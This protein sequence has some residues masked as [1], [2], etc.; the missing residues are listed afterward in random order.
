[1]FSLTASDEGEGGGSCGILKNGNGPV[2]ARTGMPGLALHTY[3]P[4][5]GALSHEAGGGQRRLMRPEKQS[6]PNIR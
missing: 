4:N 3:R 6:Q 1:M 2:S 5:F